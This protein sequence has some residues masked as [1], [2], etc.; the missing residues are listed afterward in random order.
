MIDV[1]CD[2]AG[3]EANQL[4]HAYESTFRIF[5]LDHQRC[6]AMKSTCPRRETSCDWF[7]K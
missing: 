3:A 6:M 5:L 2:I 7:L 4:R 1:T